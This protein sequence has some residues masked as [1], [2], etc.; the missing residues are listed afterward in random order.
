MNYKK[1]ILQIT[2]VNAPQFCGFPQRLTRHVPYLGIPDGTW[3]ALLDPNYSVPNFIQRET[4][5]IDLNGSSS[6]IKPEM[7]R[8]REIGI[9]GEA[10][11]RY[12]IDFISK[13][14]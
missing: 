13:M 1:N 12:Y 5:R 10:I 2:F 7:H 14:L 9:M 8:L 11:I 6:P 3:N 4:L